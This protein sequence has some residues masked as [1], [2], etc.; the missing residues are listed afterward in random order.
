L[1]LWGWVPKFAARSSDRY[2]YTANTKNAIRS[3]N[4]SFSKSKL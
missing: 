3:R 2:R 4:P 1:D